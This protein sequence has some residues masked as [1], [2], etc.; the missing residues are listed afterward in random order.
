[1][2]SIKFY[3]ASLIMKRDA[4][5]FSLL[6]CESNAASLKAVFAVEVD[7]TVFETDCDMAQVV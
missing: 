4:M 7:C 5:F 2:V 3:L 1:M 6:I